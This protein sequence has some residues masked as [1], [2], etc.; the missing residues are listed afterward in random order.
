MIFFDQNVASY[1]ERGDLR[2]GAMLP[3]D[4]ETQ[5]NKFYYAAYADG[6]LDGKTKI[7]IGMGVGM[8]VGCYP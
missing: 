8:A 6:E 3:S 2:G 4:L 7:L 1:N 5:F